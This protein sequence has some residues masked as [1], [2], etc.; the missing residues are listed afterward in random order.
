MMS[1][2]NSG[3]SGELRTETWRQERASLLSVVPIT[4]HTS[5]GALAWSQK[6][7]GLS[8]CVSFGLQ[9]SVQEEK[10]IKLQSRDHHIHTLVCAL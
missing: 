4:V 5:A 3:G 9:T 7:T 6:E 8:R 10:N 2:A 1:E